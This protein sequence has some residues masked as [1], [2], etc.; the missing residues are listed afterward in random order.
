MD[1]EPRDLADR[2]EAFAY[3]FIGG[4][5]LYWFWKL[6]L[7]C[8]YTLLPIAVVISLLMASSASLFINVFSGVVITLG[9]VLTICIHVL[10]ILAKS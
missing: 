4:P 5:D 9:F 6:F 10:Y 1:N 7:V 2:I 8:M 3:R